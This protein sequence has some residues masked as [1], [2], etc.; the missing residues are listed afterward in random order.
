[1]GFHWKSIDCLK[2]TPNRIYP[3]QAKNDLRP[4]EGNARATFWCIFT[5]HGGVMVELPRWGSY[6]AGV[7]QGPMG[8]WGSLGAMGP[9]LLNGYP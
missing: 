4:P 9:Q 1:M 3:A 6:G 7:I 5:R 2:S 8:R